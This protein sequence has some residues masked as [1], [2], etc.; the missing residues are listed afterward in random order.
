MIPH[1]FGIE[2]EY[3]LYVEGRSAG[4]QVEDARA[5]VAGSGLGRAGL[6]D[7]RHES[8][9]ADLRGFNVAALTVDPVDAEF[10]RGRSYASN[11]EVRADRVLPN[12]ARF[13]NDHGHP[14]YSTPECASLSDLAAEDL[15]GQEVVLLAAQRCAATSGRAVKVYKNNTDFHGA[16]YGTHENF[17]APRAWGFD[18]I[19]QAV[20]PI[21]VVRQVLTG[22]GKVGAETGSPCRYQISQRADFFSELASVDTLFKRPIFNTRDE[23]HADPAQWI[24]LHVISGD[25]NMMPGCTMRKVGLVQLAL[26]LEAA[27]TAPRWEFADPVRAFQTLSRDLSFRFEVPLRSGTATAYDVL[28]SYFSAA[29][30]EGLASELVAECRMLLEALR[31]DPSKAAPHIDYLAKLKLLEEVAA[32]LGTGWDDPSLRSYDLEYHNIDPDAGLY[33][34]LEAMGRIAPWNPGRP[35]IP[36]RARVRGLATR[37]PECVAA[38]W[39]TVTFDLSGQRTTIELDPG[40]DYAHVETTPDVVTFIRS[41]ETP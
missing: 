27:G 12:G 1:L 3:G 10:D 20:I 26:D 21:L 18:R 28:E 33:T 37:Y 31:T 7:Y 14:E 6:W 4:D 19:A 11:E 36:T 9:R 2:T 25:S 24:R 8:P 5:F 32:S 29:E 15:R 40:R 38:T 30:Q 34:A 16:S 22:A 41:L 39:R 17:L 35:G 23:P 13:Y